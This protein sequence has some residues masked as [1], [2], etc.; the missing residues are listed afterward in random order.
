MTLFEEEDPKKSNLE[1][2]KTKFI[3]QVKLKAA[4][5]GVPEHVLEEFI[6]HWTEHNDEGYVMAFEKI[7]RKGV[8]NIT[9]RLKTFMRNDQKW[10]P[11]NYEPKEQ[12]DD[13]DNWG[14]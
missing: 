1:E 5:L 9:K 2:R 11:S 13:I 12:T 4:P 7:K 14:R 6:D 8:F 3:E 10:N